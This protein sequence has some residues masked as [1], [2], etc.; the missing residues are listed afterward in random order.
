MRVIGHDGTEYILEIGNG[1]RYS[2]QEIRIQ[3]KDIKTNTRDKFVEIYI[4]KLQDNK[5]IWKM[6][7]NHILKKLAKQ[8]G[9]RYERRLP[10]WKK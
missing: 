6:Q 1:K 2:L 3:Y 7:S 4:N 5:R 8:N 10:K 9:W